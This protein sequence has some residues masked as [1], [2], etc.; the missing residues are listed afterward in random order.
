MAD[1]ASERILLT[2][3]QPFTNHKG[4]QLGFGSDGF[5]YLGLGDGGGAGDPNGN[6][7]NL[8]TLLGKM[9]RN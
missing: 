5:L 3:N 1:P 9:L 2:V 4:G 8:T 6:G 7:Q